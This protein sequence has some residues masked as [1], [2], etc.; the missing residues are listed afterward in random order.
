MQQR[1]VGQSGQRVVCRLEGDGLRTF[2]ELFEQQ[3]A[4]EGLRALSRAGLQER[5]VLR[6]APARSEVQVQRADLSLADLE[7]EHV[8]WLVRVSGLP[9]R[10]VLS[11][12]R[13]TD[14]E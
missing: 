6:G 1:A 7:R 2:A 8:R 4:S 9:F 14:D 12:H 5:P 11:E 3:R 13:V 10:D